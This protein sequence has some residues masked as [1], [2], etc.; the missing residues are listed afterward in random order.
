MCA[1][2]HM[3]GRACAKNKNL[4]LAELQSTAFKYLIL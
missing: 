4:D 2:K 3:H 1:E